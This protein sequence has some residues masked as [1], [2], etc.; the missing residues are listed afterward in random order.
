MAEANEQQ[1]V[2]EVNVARVSNAIADRLVSARH[3]NIPI[4]TGAKGECPIKFIRKYERVA[5]ALKWDESTKRDKFP[6]YLADAGEEFHY[7]YVDCPDDDDKPE[8]WEA[9]KKAFLDHFMRGDYKSHLSKELR[10]RKKDPNESMVVYITA[11]Q[12][13]CHDLDENM[14][15]VQIVE[16]C[17]NGLD[18][19]IAAQI[20]LFNPDNVSHLLMCAKNVEL[21]ND[22]K[23][24]E[25]NESSGSKTKKVNAINAGNS[26]AQ[27]LD[28]TV[29]SAV[30]NLSESINNLQINR[31]KFRGN[32]RNGTFKRAN[33]R[34][35]NG[36]NGNNVQNF[37]N[38]SA[39]QRQ[40]NN[41]YQGNGN[42]NRNFR[43]NNVNRNNFNGNQYQGN[44]YSRNANV[45][46]YRCSRYGHRQAECRTPMPPTS[47]QNNASNSQTQNQNNSV[48][49]VNTD[50]PVQVNEQANVQNS[51]QANVHVNTSSLHLKNLIE[52]DVLI[53]G[54]K[55]KALVDSGAELTLMRKSVADVLKL[56]L[57]PY[58]GPSLETCDK[59]VISTFGKTSVAI[60]IPNVNILVE[61]PF[62][63][64]E[65]LPSDLLLG[66]DSL[67]KFKF[68]IDCNKKCVTIDGKAIN[69][70]TEIVDKT[71]GTTCSTLKTKTSPDVSN[72]LKTEVKA[73]FEDVRMKGNL[74]M[75]SD[76]QI[77]PKSILTLKVKTNGQTDVGNVLAFSEEYHFLKTGLSLQNTVSRTLDGILKVNA[78]NTS[79]NILALKTGDVIGVFEAISDRNIF[80]I[81]LSDNEMD[82]H[83]NETVS[84]F[85]SINS[86]NG[87]NYRDITEKEFKIDFI[88]VN[89]G[90]VKC[91]P[92]LTPEQKLELK[93]SLE[94]FP[95]VLTFD[96]KRVGKIKGYEYKLIMNPNAQPVHHTPARTS[97]E[98]MALIENEIDKLVEK[99]IV[100][101]SISEYS[102]RTVLVKRAD[103]RPRVCIDY[104]DVNIDLQA[105]SYPVPDLQMCLRTVR[106]AKYIT[107]LDM[108]DSFHQIPLSP[109][110]IKYT[111]FVTP[112]GRFFEY[113]YVPY[114]LRV[115]TAAFQR[116]LDLATCGLKYNELACF[117]DDLLI[118]GNT[119]SKQL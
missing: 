99:G 80:P 18:P 87:Q 64:V 49:N 1:D 28:E 41:N 43:A 19:D 75:V 74:H 34:Q 103:G 63:I 10:S 20:Q 88:D 7:I 39:N 65:R 40:N 5:K 101:P 109:E 15:Q 42:G 94:K 72:K 79:T 85:S 67:G 55:F 12:T 38:N 115:S 9:L 66:M 24:A 116:A 61:I 100:Q 29:L 108:N 107:K 8:N 105:D 86:P 110:S 81:D 13:I 23:K 89:G 14:S 26:E 17:L 60:N 119:W 111:A 78:I 104:R 69:N 4:F 16:Y 52:I 53:N 51:V 6:N 114:G 90:R 45:Q 58:A 112:S 47:A 98:N 21:S 22:R 36:Y 54:Y 30:I 106:N 92:H 2:T 82:M 93:H 62:I 96:E 117:V 76:T 32:G 25:T 11:I 3:H 77:N 27:G 73:C 71:F 91:G 57:S 113:K 95:D 84:D 97:F 44:G 102:S 56:N 46:C 37:V 118:P 83:S 70:L 59:T 50:V 35:N 31:N 48:N 68:K 33:N